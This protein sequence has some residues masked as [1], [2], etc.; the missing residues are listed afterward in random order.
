MP[1]SSSNRCKWAYQN[2]SM[3]LYHDDQWGIPN[4]DDQIFFEF[5]VLESA[6]AGLS[7]NTI[8]QKRNDYK[9]AYANFDPLKV[10]SFSQVD[11]ELMLKNFNI[12]RNYKKI[13]S[14]ISNANKFLEVQK[15]FGSFANFVWKFVSNK[16]VSHSINDPSQIPITIDESEKLYST[17]KELGFKFFGPIITYSFMQAMGLVND[18]ELSCFKRI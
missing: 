18:H 7:W 8:L 6:Q 17:M 11:I 16:P 12:V 5:I 2:A 14:S 9:I 15:V 4:Y 13:E 1:I 10:S 3:T